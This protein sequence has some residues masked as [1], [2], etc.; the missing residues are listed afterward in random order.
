MI[1]T[2]VPAR[3]QQLACQTARRSAKVQQIRRGGRYE[4]QAATVIP[5]ELPLFTMTKSESAVLWVASRMLDA[6]M[7]K[8]LTS[9]A[10]VSDVPCSFS[11]SLSGS[12]NRSPVQ[13]VVHSEAPRPAAVPLRHL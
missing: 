6:D 10:R 12:S 9:S 1:V 13:A 8:L 11:Q 2:M 5:S 4:K 3:L 7:Y